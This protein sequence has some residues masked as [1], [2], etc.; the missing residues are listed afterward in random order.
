MAGQRRRLGGAVAGAALCVLAA[1]AA[2]AHP[3]T[4]A[5]GALSEVEGQ[6]PDAGPER[7]LPRTPDGRP[8]LSGVWQAMTTAHVD[9]EPH[10]AAREAPAGLGVV[11]G[12][13]LPYQPPALA[14]REENRR[15]RAARDTE[16]R[17]FLPGV[18]RV[19]YMPFP[20][21]IVQTPKLVMMLF[22]YANATRNVFMDTPHLEGPIE[23]WMGDSRGRWEGET[24]VVSVTH[25]NDQTWFDRAGNFH[26]EAMQ[27]LERYTMITPDHI[28]YTATIT[29][30]KVFTRSWTMSLVLY[31]HLEPSAQLLDYPCYAFELGDTPLRPSNGR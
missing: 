5:Q 14:Q 26:S 2:A 19:M 30:P 22:E 13:E 29:D 28:R 3:S 7:P 31:R 8:D 12:G 15:S 24:L 16:A 1:A 11:D 9:I 18:P 27:V 4:D 6:V 23:W 17:C 20:F 25:F 21:Q 10:A